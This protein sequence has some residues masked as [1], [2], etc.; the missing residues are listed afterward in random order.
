MDKSL[1]SGFICRVVSLCKLLC[2]WLVGQLKGICIRYPR[3]AG[4]SMINVGN[5]VSKEKQSDQT[6]GTSRSYYIRQIQ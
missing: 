2:L 5:M 4:S 6:E 3:I 1:I